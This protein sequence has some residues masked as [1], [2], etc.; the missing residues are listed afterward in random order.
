MYADIASSEDNAHS[1]GECSG[2]GKCNYQ[3]GLCQCDTANGFYGLSCQYKLCPNNCSSHGKCISL[4]QAAQNYDGW[5]LNHTTSYSSNW[6]ANLLFGCQCDPGY[7]GSDCS[8]PICE[9]GPDPRLTNSFQ[10]TV[11]LVCETNSVTRS[12]K[13]KLRFHG[14]VMKNFLNI[15]SSTIADLKRELMKINSEYAN[16]YPSLYSPLIVTSDE[17]N[18][19]ICSP[20][21]STTITTTIKYNKRRGDVSALSFYFRKLTGASLYFQ[22]TISPPP[23]SPP[24]FLSARPTLL[25]RIDSSLSTP[26]NSISPMRLCLHSLRRLLPTYL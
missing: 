19:L 26:D 18:G 25:F 12:G 17:P 3:T 7:S 10:E 5:S 14:K 15:S 20:T 2:R 22:V 1:Y 21:A 13:F 24:M 11:T 9:S 4:E 16:I 8:E 6:D 23:P